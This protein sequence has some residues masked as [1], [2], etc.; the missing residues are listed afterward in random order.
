[1]PKKTSIK[2][3]RQRKRQYVREKK[4]NEGRSRLRRER[5]AE[6]KETGITTMERKFLEAIKGTKLK[7][8]SIVKDVSSSA[9]Y[10]SFKIELVSEGGPIARA[11]LIVTKSNERGDA[12]SQERP[13]LELVIEQIQGIA[14]HEKNIKKFFE[15]NKKPWNVALV[16]A[17]VTVAYKLGFDRVLLRDPTTMKD[18]HEPVLPFYTFD[19]P[20]AS[21]DPTVGHGEGQVTPQKFVEKQK[22]DIR[23][24]M[25][26]LYTRTRKTCDFTKKEGD[27]FVR[28]FP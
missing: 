11:K 3:R 7:N 1:M 24:R 25:Q 28:E 23:R 27:Y 18:Y 21:D 10:V 6:V 9:A 13:R 4:P 22:E 8:A 16:N 17:I 12:N 15:N 5:V 26:E 14:R 19:D 20:F 2:P